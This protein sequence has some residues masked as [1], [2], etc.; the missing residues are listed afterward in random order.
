MHLFLTSAGGGRSVSRSC[1]LTPVERFKLNRRLGGPQS[2]SGH[3]GTERDFLPLTRMEPA[4]LGRAAC[5]LVT[6]PITVYRTVTFVCVCV[7]LIFQY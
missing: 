5:N 6:V 4:V 7:K 3:F 2:R 1:C